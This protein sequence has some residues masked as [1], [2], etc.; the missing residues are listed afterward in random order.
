MLSNITVIETSIR[1]NC[2]VISYQIS[3]Q[4][5][6]QICRTENQQQKKADNA[7]GQRQIFKKIN[8]KCLYRLFFAKTVKTTKSLLIMKKM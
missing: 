4:Q 8:Y 7:E 2:F 1:Q 6:S 5:K 3:T